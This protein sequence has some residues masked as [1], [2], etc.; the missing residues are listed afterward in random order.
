MNRDGNPYTSLVCAHYLTGLG[1]DEVGELATVG[2]AIGRLSIGVGNVA[3]SLLD[4]SGIAWHDHGPI[5]HFV[6]LDGKS[7]VALPRLFGGEL[8]P[9]LA[10]ALMTVQCISRS[11]LHSRSRSLC[12]W[13]ETAARKHRFVALFQSLTALEIMRRDGIHPPHSDEMMALLEDPES[14]WILGQSKLRNGLVHLG[15]EDIASS[16]NPGSTVDDAVRA[17]TGQNP[18]DVATRVE[19]HLVRFVKLLT[20]WMLTPTAR[21]DTFLG[22]LHAAPPD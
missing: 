11:A 4:S 12:A 22:A 20:T 3:G 14:E 2:P 13:C 5:P 6:W 16:L 19:N 17:Y 21:G 8:D 10:A 7:T 18:E 1:A 15:F 9:P